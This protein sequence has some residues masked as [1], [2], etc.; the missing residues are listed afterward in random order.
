[1]NIQF[2]KNKYE[3]YNRKIAKYTQ[4]ARTLY[5]QAEKALN[6]KKINKYTN[7]K[8]RLVS[9]YLLKKKMLLLIWKITL[10]ILMKPKFYHQ[11]YYQI[12]K[13]L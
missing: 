2:F 13:K 9:K 7:F 3:L 8:E 4:K 10:D 5:S 12:L 1:M 11:S 6:A